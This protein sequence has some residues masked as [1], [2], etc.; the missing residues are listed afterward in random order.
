MGFSVVWPEVRFGQNDV[1]NLI[2][3]I[4]Y[5]NLFKQLKLN[6]NVT[7]LRDLRTRDLA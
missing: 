3:L 7:A 6:N 5:K 4:K 1:L 2:L